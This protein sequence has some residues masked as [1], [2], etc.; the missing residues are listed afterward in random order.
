[1][2]VTEKAVDIHMA[3]IRTKAGSDTKTI[4]RPNNVQ[5]VEIRIFE[6]RSV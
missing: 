4:E 2:P 1:M 5:P 6:R 3:T